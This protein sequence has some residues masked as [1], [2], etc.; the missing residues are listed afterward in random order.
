[1]DEKKLPQVIWLA[2][3]NFNGLITPKPVKCTRQNKYGHATY[4]NRS[5]NL[6]IEAKELGLHQ[7]GG[8]IGICTTFTS[9]TKQDVELFITGCLAVTKVLDNMCWS[10]RESKKPAKKHKKKTVADKKKTIKRAI[11]RAVS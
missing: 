2:Q 8:A 4:Y 9:E 7:S 10:Y 5:G 3:V 6:G 11:N 1:M